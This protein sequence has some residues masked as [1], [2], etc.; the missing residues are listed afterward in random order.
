[1]NHGCTLLQNYYGKNR[2]IE[3]GED[4]SDLLDFLFNLPTVKAEALVPPARPVV[5]TRLAQRSVSTWAQGMAA[6]KH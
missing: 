2:S 6:V 3:A 5:T 1:M 4:R